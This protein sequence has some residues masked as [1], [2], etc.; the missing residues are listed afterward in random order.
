MDGLIAGLAVSALGA[1]LIIGTILQR[2]QGNTAAVATTLAYPIGD[3][4]LLASVTAV[5]ALTGW[6]PGRTW[7]V[8]G[9]G[10]AL[11]AVGDGP[12]ATL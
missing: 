3:V 6:R 5:L 1:A 7:A 8:L 12:A 11:S 9:A 10:L 2:A 4:L